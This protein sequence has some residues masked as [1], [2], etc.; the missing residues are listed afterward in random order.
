MNATSSVSTVGNTDSYALRCHH[1]FL[2]PARDNRLSARRGEQACSRGNNEHAAAQ[3]AFRCQHQAPR[4]LLWG[5]YTSVST[6]DTRAF[7]RWTADDREISVIGRSVCSSSIPQPS[8]C[9]PTCSSRELIAT[10]R[11]VRIKSG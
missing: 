7:F 2:L 5:Q 8:H 11:R 9:S 1:A 6:S 3:H 4:G 10:R